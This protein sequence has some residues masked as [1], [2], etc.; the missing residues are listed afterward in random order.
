MPRNSTADGLPD[1]VTGPHS[2]PQDAGRISSR[3]RGR[4]LRRRASRCTWMFRVNSFSELNAG[5]SPRAAD[6]GLQKGRGGAGLPRVL[7]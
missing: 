5:L 6:L 7:A 1:R 3:H 4:F 2:H